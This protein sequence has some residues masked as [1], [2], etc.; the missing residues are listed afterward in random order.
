MFGRVHV[1]GDL[2]IAA[3]ERRAVTAVRQT[4]GN[5]TLL[6]ISLRAFTHSG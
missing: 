4:D 6:A 5:Y 2:A 3:I 1:E